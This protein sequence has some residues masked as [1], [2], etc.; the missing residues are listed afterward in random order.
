MAALQVGTG[1]E[2]DDPHTSFYISFLTQAYTGF[3]L[4]TAIAGLATDTRA[5][6]STQAGQNMLRCQ[7][8]PTLSRRLQKSEAQP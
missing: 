4:D 5:D 6:S 3:Y 2:K 8:L 1:K 7:R